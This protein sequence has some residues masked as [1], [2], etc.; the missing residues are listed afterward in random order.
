MASAWTAWCCCMSG[1]RWRSERGADPA[2]AIDGLGGPASSMLLGMW[3]TA[4]T[5]YG[6][7]FVDFPSLEQ[8]GTLIGHS[9]VLCGILT[10]VL[11]PA[12]LPLRRPARPVAVALDAAIRGMGRP[13]AHG[14]SRRGSRRDR[15]PGCRRNPAAHQSDAGSAAVRDARRGTSPAHRA[16][17]RIAR[18]CLCRDGGR[19]E[20]AGAAGI[21]RAAPRRPRSRAAW[22]GGAGADGAAPLAGDAGSASSADSSAGL[23]APATAA[24]LV[25]AEKTEGFRP[26]SFDPFREQLPALL[27]AESPDL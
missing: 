24:A 11:V 14:H 18:R 15:S 10:L 20:S 19:N 4:A 7:T 8:L 5:F 2:A 23:S 16:D 13:A 17:V 25:E 12:L 26:G 3:T 27:D 6:L 22:N 21:E 9:M 1:T